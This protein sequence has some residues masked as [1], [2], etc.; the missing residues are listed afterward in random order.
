[1]CRWMPYRGETIR[2]NN[3]NGPCPLPGG[4][5]ASKA[6]ESTASTN[7]D[8]FGMG[9]YSEHPEP[10]LYRDNIAPA[11][12]DENCAT[13]AAH[14]SH[15]IRHVRASTGT[16]ITRPKLSPVRLRAVWMFLHNGMSATGPGCRRERPRR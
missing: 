6:L 8:G 2:S 1:M 5:V 15:L 14:R 3:R 10:G 9:W 13:S 11:W 4:A 16:P 7:G 12:S